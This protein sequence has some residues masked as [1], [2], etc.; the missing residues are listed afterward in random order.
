MIRVYNKAI[1]DRIPEIIVE[2]GSE[3]TIEILSDEEF[4]KELEKKLEEEIKE[5]KESK[6][7]EELCD[8]IEIAHRIA[9]LQGVSNETLDQMRKKKNIERG[10]FK[11]NF[12]LV[13][14]KSKKIKNI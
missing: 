14:V 8:L 12:Y 11:E 9:E 1:R 5:Y 10:Y 6:K 13:C 3:P 2:S 4:L 7:V